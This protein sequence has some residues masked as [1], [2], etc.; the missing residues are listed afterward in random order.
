LDC[1]LDIFHITLCY[2]FLDQDPASSWLDIRKLAAVDLSR[3]LALERT[4]TLLLAVL[5]DLRGLVGAVGG[6][7]TLLLT[8]TAGASELACNGL[9]GAFGLGVT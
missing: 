1:I 4:V 3:V 6:T 2:G 5:A 7:M 9:V 8:E